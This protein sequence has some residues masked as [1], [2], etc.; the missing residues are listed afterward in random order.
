MIK[1]P[2]CGQ[3]Q[4]QGKKQKKGGRKYVVLTIAF[5]MA[6]A[7][8]GGVFYFYQKTKEQNEQHAFEK[9]L[10]SNEAMVLE[11]YLNQY[12]NAPA[13]HR[14]SVRILLEEMKRADFEWRNAV[15]SLSKTALQRYVRQHPGD[16]HNTEAL[17]LIDS[18]DW[19]TAKGRDKEEDYQHYMDEHADGAYYDEARLAMENLEAIRLQQEKAASDSMAVVDA[20]KEEEAHSSM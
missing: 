1:S 4:K 12:I 16:V 6:L 18:I 3:H 20:Q 11:N 5:L 9:A 13:Q 10:L 14:D 8:F 2:E 17:L 7:V 15:A 19:V